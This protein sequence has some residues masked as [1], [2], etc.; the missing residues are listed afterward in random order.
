MRAARLLSI[1]MMLEARGPLTARQLAGEL[2]ISL[3]TLHRD[4]DHLSAAGVPVVAE[5]GRFG[6]FR[7]IDGW[8]TRLTGLTPS[9]AQAVFLSGLAG[10]AAQLGLQ[11]P[12]RSA[13]LKLLVSLPASWREEAS[14]VHSRLH[15]DP[16]DWY[17]EPDPVPHLATV[18]DAVWNERQLCFRYQSWTRLSSTTTS[19][20]GLVLKAGTWY[21]LGFASHVYRTYRVASLQSAEVLQVR[22]ARPKG[23]DLPRQWQESVDRLQSSIYS[24]VA[25]V[26]ATAVGLKS[27][28]QMHAAALRAVND[29]VRKPSPDERVIV[30]LPIESIETATAQ[31]L[32]LAPDVIV[33]EPKALLLSIQTRL[34]EISGAYAK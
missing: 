19:P 29:A 34:R 13:Q 16:V 2:E 11:G 31:L 10:P 17:R 14:K 20:L 18:A 28:G 1:Q 8:S 21:F 9:E 24:G 4:I 7:L 32:A 30:R 15:V 5:R 26:S 22:A 3:R 33:L 25:R 27:L 23:F 6:G 12:L